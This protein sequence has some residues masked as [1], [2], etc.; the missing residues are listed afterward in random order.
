MSE[1][2]LCGLALHQDMDVSRENIL[3][4]FRIIE[5]DILSNLQLSKIY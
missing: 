1:D 3:K 2:M 5:L 4:R